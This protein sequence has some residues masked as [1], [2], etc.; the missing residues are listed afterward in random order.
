MSQETQFTQEQARTMYGTLQHIAAYT[1][2]PSNDALV[3]VIRQK[4]AYAVTSI[5]RHTLES[6]DSQ[7]ALNTTPPVSPASAAAEAELP[8]AGS[9]RYTVHRMGLIHGGLCWIYDTDTGKYL[10][11]EYPYYDAQAECNRLN[12][13][14]AASPANGDAA[15]GSGM[16][17]N[18]GES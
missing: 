4:A 12:A 10:D 3:D 18:G 9:E 17:G 7:Q 8:L 13:A 14:H 15:T 2:N 1:I 16:Q 5:A 6:I 11:G